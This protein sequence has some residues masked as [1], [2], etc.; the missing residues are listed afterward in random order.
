MLHGAELNSAASGANHMP[1]LEAR[2]FAQIAVRR[3]IEY[4]PRAWGITIL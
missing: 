2:E 4:S 1:E 3:W